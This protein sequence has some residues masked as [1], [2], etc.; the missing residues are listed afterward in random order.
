MRMW[1]AKREP[2][3]R[4]KTV[5][6][7]NSPASR[8]VLS[9]VGTCPRTTSPGLN[10]LTRFLPTTSSGRYWKRRL[11]PSPNVSMRPSMSQVMTLRS[12]AWAWVGLVGMPARARAGAGLRLPVG[13]NR[14]GVASACSALPPTNDQTGIAGS[15]GR[16]PRN[17]RS[18]RTPFRGVGGATGPNLLRRDLQPDA[19]QGAGLVLPALDALLGDLGAQDVGVEGLQVGVHLVG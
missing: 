17:P 12:F 7:S 18:P 2:S 14:P 13:N 5:S 11:A 9:Q 4:T 15:P 16:L 1:A 19:L 8:A 6:V 10:R 3:L